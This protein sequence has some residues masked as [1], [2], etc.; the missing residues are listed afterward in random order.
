MIE[1]QDLI[2]EARTNPTTP[3]IEAL[4]RAVFFLGAWYFLPAKKS[5]GA[6]TPMVIE[7]EDGAWLLCFTNFR[8]LSA[9]EAT[10]DQLLPDGQVNML[11]LDPLE[12]CRLISKH[13]EHIRGVIFNPSS[14][15]TFRAPTSALLAYANHFGL[16]VS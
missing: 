11:V 15:Q 13:S 7:H 12:S 16:D 1:I 14:D 4:W 2:I 3:N 6:S 8:T 5:V 10:T 9:F